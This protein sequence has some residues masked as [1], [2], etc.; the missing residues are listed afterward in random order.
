[1]M[2]PTRRLARFHQAGFTLMELMVGMTIGMIATIIIVQVMSV[3]EAQKRTTTG[4]ADAQ[5]NGGIALY[6]IGRE[7][8]M[9]GFPLY[10]GVDTP[11]SCT[12][13]TSSVAGL[14]ADLTPVAITEVAAVAG[15]SPAYDKITI[16]YGSP[17]GT[18]V[19]T[20][21]S[22]T[23]VPST[24]GASGGA[25]A[26]GGTNWAVLSSLGCQVGDITVINTGTT[27]AISKVLGVPS[28]AS[29]ELADT[30]GAASGASLA[31]V[32]AWNEITYEVDATTGN[33][34]RT[35]KVNGLTDGTIVNGVTTGAFQSVVGIVNIQAQ[36]GIS[37]AGNVNQVSSW[38]P[39]SG[40]TWATVAGVTPTVANR[41]RIKALRVAVVARNAKLEQSIVTT[42]QPVP[43]TNTV[44]FDGAVWAGP[45]IDLSPGVTKWNY[46][47][48]RVFETTIPLR[49]VIWS[50]D[51][52]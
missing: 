20:A 44:T 26:H 50:K 47:R 48:Y 3:F 36:Y 12:T 28:A 51:T 25:G 41:N 10:P 19:G 27:C 29:V 33:L 17:L 43:W 37:S 18:G 49:N 11:L 2:T 42:A 4:T 35:A 23:G 15:V 30:T 24:M 32:G 46:Y 14:T 31:C 22:T 7:M 40:G 34:K 6:S 13:T 39:A 45:T 16:R 8:A 38:V 52:L 9:A 21:G 5:T 1:M